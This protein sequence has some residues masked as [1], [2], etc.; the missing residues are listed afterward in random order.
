M[1]TKTIVFN[2]NTT[3]PSNWIWQK[4][5]GQF[6]ENNGHGWEKSDTI[7]PA[8]KRSLVITNDYLFD[9]L[10]QRWTGLSENEIDI[11]VPLNTNGIENY[12][13][14]NNESFAVINESV[15]CNGNIFYW[16]NGDGTVTI[17]IIYDID[18]N[19]LSVFFMISPETSEAYALEHELSPE[20]Y[21]N[22]KLEDF[23]NWCGFEGFN[24]F[25][26]HEVKI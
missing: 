21:P 8:E 13:S 25:E 14:Q 17:Q 18:Y 12:Y 7:E 5:D 6:Y 11:S 2:E 23:L 26:I 22:V 3:P 20:D 4:E 19:N 10:N 1:N 9:L 15:I 16:D 24:E